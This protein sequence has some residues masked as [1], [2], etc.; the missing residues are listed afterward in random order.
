MCVP[1]VTEFCFSRELIS[2]SRFI[3]STCEDQSLKGRRHTH[4][5]ITRHYEE[6]N[7]NMYIVTVAKEKKKFQSKYYELKYRIVNFIPDIIFCKNLLYL[8]CTYHIQRTS[9]YISLLI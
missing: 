2:V 9:Y 1:L 8:K 3:K 6:S 4:F 7:K 5:Q